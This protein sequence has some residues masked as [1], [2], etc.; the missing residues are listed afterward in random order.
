MVATLNH[1]IVMTIIP[2]HQTSVILEQDVIT[3]LR[4]VSVVMGTLAQKMMSA[5]VVLAPGT[6]SIVTTLPHVLQKCATRSL[7]VYTKTRTLLVDSVFQ[8][9]PSPVVRL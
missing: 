4:R 9:S 2:V 1:W 6:S 8:I 3:F 7:A 5:V